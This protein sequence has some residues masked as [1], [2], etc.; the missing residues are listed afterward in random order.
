M[1][2]YGKMVKRALG[3]AGLAG[4]GTAA[5]PDEAEALFAGRL[6]RTANKKALA[7]AHVMERRGLDPS[8]IYRGTGW[9]RGTD[10]KW[11]FEIPDAQ[12][13]LRTRPSDF[14]PPQRFDIRKPPEE[15]ASTMLSER[16]S[17][18]RLYMAYPELREAGFFGFPAEAL[19]GVRG[20]IFETPTPRGSVIGL[21]SD[22]ARDPMET[23]STMLHEL[24]HMIQSIEGFAPGG[25]TTNPA[26]V[27]AA[28]RELGMPGASLALLE[29]MPAGRD[30]LY[31]AYRRLAGEAEAR[32]VQARINNNL[33]PPWATMDVPA[34]QQIPLPPIEHQPWLP[35]RRLPIGRR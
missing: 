18:P 2:N 25:S 28:A 4:A 19:P 15:L 32:N 12:S 23:R 24:Q 16:L 9:F 29:K 7:E 31:N 5:A 27:E 8:A 10:D 35:F 21:S 14:P 33:S 6:A 17:H 34:Q 11:R 20:G 1:P 26:V 3:A 13:I 30:A 22:L